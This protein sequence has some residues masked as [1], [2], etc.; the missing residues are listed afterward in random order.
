[1]DYLEQGRFVTAFRSA[2]VL[3]KDDFVEKGLSGSGMD[4]EPLS[5]LLDSSGARLPESISEQAL[6]GD[7]LGRLFDKETE[8]PAGWAWVPL[9]SFLTILPE[10]D[11]FR[12]SKL[13]AYLNWRYN[14]NFCGRCGSKNG[15]KSDEVAR[16]C[17]KCGNLTFPRISPAILAVVS[18]GDKLL[19]ARNAMNKMKSW[20]ILAGF[21][22]PGET[23]EGC[24]KREVKEEVNIEVQTDCYLGSQPWPFPDQLMLGFSA[25]WVSGELQPDKVEIAE[26]GWF[27]PEELPPLP[28]PGSLSR[29]LIDGFFNGSLGKK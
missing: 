17:P 2:E 29:R 3:V 18:R 10:R 15:D 22:E 27:G 7:L 24:V 8:A 26:A 13:L 1:M 11:W 25:Y 20:S 28:G 21:V 23:F 9:R 14:S 16:L 4:Q 5:R 12:T 6:N 19:L